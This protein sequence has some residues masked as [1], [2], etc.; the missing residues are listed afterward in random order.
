MNS[1]E[2]FQQIIKNVV[3][4]TDDDEYDVVFLNVQES[5]VDLRIFSVK[6]INILVTELLMLDMQVVIEDPPVVVLIKG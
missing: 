3:F 1:S 5:A 6:D 4:S 2:L